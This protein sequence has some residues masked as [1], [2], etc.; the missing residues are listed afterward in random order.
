M[1]LPANS[2]NS[3]GRSVLANDPRPISISFMN[4][5]IASSTVAVDAA[6]NAKSIELDDATGFLT[7]QYLK[8]CDATS[9]RVYYGT[10]LNVVTN[11]LTLDTP[12]DSD[13]SAGAVAQGTNTNMNVDGTTPK[14][15]LLR[16]SGPFL[17]FSVDV[18][19]IMFRM[20]TATA[21]DFGK[22]GDISA[23]TNGVVIRVVNGIT[24]NIANIKNNGDIANLAYDYTPYDTSNPG[25]GVFGIGAR[26][27][28]SGQ[29]KIGSIIRIKPGEDLEVII[30]DDLT[31]ITEF[32]I[33]AQGHL[34]ET[35][36]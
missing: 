5:L 7:G 33:M 31:G 27:T 9:N 16:G 23:L 18:T 26:L 34:S 19:R 17:G 24:T 11:T 15:F 3:L 36:V 8:L 12:L 4:T 1:S 28:F 32:K 25:Q 29:S 6:K 30:Q 22:F 10:I 14:T 2:K 35:F 20:T 13:I 21:T